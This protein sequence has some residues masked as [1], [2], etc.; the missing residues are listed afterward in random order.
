MTKISHLQILSK[1]LENESEKI[2]LDCEEKK[3]K[4][5]K[6]KIVNDLLIFKQ[7]HMAKFFIT[8]KNL[9][10]CWGKTSVEN[11]ILVV[12]AFIKNTCF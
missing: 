7:K 4:I 12:D 6:E 8:D 10:L 2:N 3:L 1:E 9:M 5:E 11:K